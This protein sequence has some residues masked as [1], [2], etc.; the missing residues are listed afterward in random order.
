[1]GYG[2]VEAILVQFVS[3]SAMPLFLSPNESS[4]ECAKSCS[5]QGHRRLPVSPFEDGRALLSNSYSPLRPKSPR[6]IH[7][8]QHMQPQVGKAHP[9]RQGPPHR[10]IEQAC[11]S[12][13]QE[14][15]CER[16]PCGAT[17]DGQ[18]GVWR[19]RGRRATRAGGRAFSP[20]QLLLRRGCPRLRAGGWMDSFFL[21]CPP[22]LGAPYSMLRETAPG[23]LVEGR[24]TRDLA[25][26]AR[27]VP[28]LDRGRR[29]WMPLFG[30]RL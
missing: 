25:R 6:I 8:R 26:D 20:L 12:S 29:L 13:G 19:L 3:F 15:S 14:V 11:T 30:V 17:S 5:W 24:V 23:D 22:R 7:I 9:C 10:S 16:G 4:N 27:N 28:S 2:Q 18:F 1:M 21:S